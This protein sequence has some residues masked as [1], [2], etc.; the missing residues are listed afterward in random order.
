MD[1][2]LAAAVS[3]KK[4]IVLSCQRPRAPFRRMRAEHIDSMDDNRRVHVRVDLHAK[5]P[6]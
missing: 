2:L 6:E 4:R 5:A 3:L 1:G